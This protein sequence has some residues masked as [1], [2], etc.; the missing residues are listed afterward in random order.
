M[1]TKVPHLL[2]FQHMQTWHTTTVRN[3]VVKI[4]T[5]R[6]ISGWDNHHTSQINVCIL[7]DS[8]VVMDGRIF[9]NFGIYFN[10]CMKRLN[11]IECFVCFV[12]CFVLPSLFVFNFLTLLRCESN[13]Y[14][15]IVGF[16]LRKQSVF[17]M[18]KWTCG[19]FEC[20]ELSTVLLKPKNPSL[21]KFC[22]CSF[23][24]YWWVW[25]QVFQ[26]VWTLI[27]SARKPG[28]ILGKGGDKTFKC[29]KFK[30]TWLF[31]VCRVLTFVK[32]Q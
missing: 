4:C 15:C 13:K 9:S 27:Y 28:T 2:L 22:L 32:G 1:P 21:L 10:F 19:C 18:Q 16:F 20:V 7:Q 5:I 24:K 29:L 14:F 26:L 8:C 25:G 12:L 23:L 11:N 31:S 6:F 17:L 3:T 30:E